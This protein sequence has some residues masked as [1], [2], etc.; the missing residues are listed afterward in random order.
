[1]NIR[2]SNIPIANKEYIYIYIYIFRYFFKNIY[3]FNF[4]KI[5]NETKEIINV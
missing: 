2:N 1:M 5:K 3:F 4:I